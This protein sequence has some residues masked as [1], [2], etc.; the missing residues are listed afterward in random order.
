MANLAPLIPQMPGVK[1][2]LDFIGSGTVRRGFSS[3]LGRD[4]VTGDLYIL[5]AQKITGGYL[6][7]SSAAFVSCLM[8]R[9]R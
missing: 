9:S 8:T 5:C 6:T 3:R 7:A 2:R 1:A 4:E